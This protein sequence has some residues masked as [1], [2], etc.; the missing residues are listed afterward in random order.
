MGD[1]QRRGVL[2]SDRVLAKRVRQF[3]G[4]RTSR[5][6]VLVLV[7][8]SVGLTI[9]E[10]VLARS[11]VV[12]HLGYALTWLVG[13]EGFARI[14]SSRRRKVVAALRCAP[15]LLTMA[16]LFLPVGP[17]PAFLLL[18]LFRALR[19]FWVIEPF[20]RRLRGGTR[21]LVR[22]AL[23]AVIVVVGGSTSLLVFER[24]ENPSLATPSLAGWSVF[25]SLVAG[26]PIPAPPSTWGGR[27]TS[28][29]VIAAG[30][31]GF[32]TIA[33]TA[34]AL[35]TETIRIGGPMV[36]WEELE[37]H[38]VICGWN[39][40]AE[41]VVREVTQA[42]QRAD[43]PIVVITDAEGEPVFFDPL[44][45]ARVQFLQADFTEVATLERAGI[46]RASKCILLTDTSRG[47]SERDADARTILAALTIERLNRDVYTCAE[48]HSREHVPHLRMGNVNDYVVSGEHS[49]FL[50]AQAA[51]TKG[52][53]G[54]F[55]ELLTLEYGNKF[56]SV[57]V[58]EAWVGR[59]FRELLT[60]MKDSHDALLV[61][62]QC[63]DG[64]TKVNPTKHTF[65][66]GE[67]LVVIS[68][69]DITL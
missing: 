26:E 19:L 27:V 45:R 20:A 61:G 40:K 39:R 5:W 43:A 14:A 57:P 65:E 22:V 54:I 67:A 4:S 68:S 12:T 60:H 51:L 64:T 49:A 29:L 23:A 30:L 63:A 35:V 18:R 50:L 33:G 10:L 7:V 21:A 41:L 38:L 47:R 3:L 15:E 8:A 66:M 32:A 6:L 42:G 31:A 13:L 59:G 58:P 48:V 53:M 55:Q 44:L 36:D 16:T 9:A 28:M 37:G 11:A 56:V 24:P 17:T 52:V 1:L 34:G 25:Y 69:R 62:V 46:R 2:Y